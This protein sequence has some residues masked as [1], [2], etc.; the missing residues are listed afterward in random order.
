MAS[1]H[2]HNQWDSKRGGKEK[3]SRFIQLKNDVSNKPQVE[4][5]RESERERTKLHEFIWMSDHFGIQWFFTFC[6]CVKTVHDHSMA[7]CMFRIRSQTLIY[8]FLLRMFIVS[9]HKTDKMRK[10]ERNIPIVVTIQYGNK[11]IEFPSFA[12]NFCKKRTK[13]N[14]HNNAM[15]IYWLAHLLS[16]SHFP[17]APLKKFR[18]HFI[19]LLSTWIV[20]A[21]QNTSYYCL[22]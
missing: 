10:F 1:R 11:P 6:L 3:I 13:F 22:L 19:V 17:V 2:I 8:S 20:H 14:K 16:L 7:F 5:K 12:F 4:E 18:S 15:P 9:I 21:I